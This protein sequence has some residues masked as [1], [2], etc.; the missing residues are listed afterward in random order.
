M[1]NVKSSCFFAKLQFFAKFH[2]YFA[3]FFGCT[4]RPALYLGASLSLLRLLT[5]L[6][7]KKRKNNLEIQKIYAILNIAYS[8]YF[9]A[10]AFQRGNYHK[11]SDL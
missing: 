9:T 1:Q 10:H 7:V 2:P 5:R 8:A 11:N 3:H 6:F 4:V